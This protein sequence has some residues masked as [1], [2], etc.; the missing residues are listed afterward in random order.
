MKVRPVITEASI[1][2]LKL[3][4]YTFRLPSVLNK[5]EIKKIIKMVYR[6]EVKAVRTMTRPSKRKFSAKRRERKLRSKE[7]IAIVELKKGERIS[8]L[9]ALIV[10]EKSSKKKT[11]RKTDRS[12]ESDD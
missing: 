2:R 9:D 7:T 10:E 1:A 3:P 12:E 8:D 6:V 5:T 11:K 4:R